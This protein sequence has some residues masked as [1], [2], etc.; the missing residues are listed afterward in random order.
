VVPDVV[1]LAADKLDWL[2]TSAICWEDFLVAI[3][4]IWLI[5]RRTILW[6]DSAPEETNL[7]EFCN[8]ILKLFYFNVLRL[9]D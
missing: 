4:A 7:A 8:K 2:L 9:L 3:R 6:P 1:Q 5:C